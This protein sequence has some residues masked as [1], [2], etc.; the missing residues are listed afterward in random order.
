MSE[1]EQLPPNYWEQ[2]AMSLQA[3]INDIYRLVGWEG[4]EGDYE[5]TYP[6]RKRLRELQSQLHDLEGIVWALKCAAE[7]ALDEDGYHLGAD[8]KQSLEDAVYRAK[9]YT[10]I[11]RTKTDAVS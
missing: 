10:S 5:I 9:T 8:V 6:V 7:Y 2:R 4:S 11:C 1:H 3:T